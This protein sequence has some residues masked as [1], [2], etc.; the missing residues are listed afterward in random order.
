MAVSPVEIRHVR[1]KKTF[2]GGFRRPAVEELLAEIADSFEE[3]W[4]ERADLRD[5]VDHL[6]AEL[7]R[8]REVE[9]LLRETL[10][11]AERSAIELKDQARTEA[12]LVVREAHTSARSITQEALVERERLLGE[13]ARVRALLQAALTSVGESV[14]VAVEAAAEAA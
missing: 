4:R 5:R 9:G 6:E 10:L 3:V 2:I 11:S 7:R 14:P 8:H 13:A 1:L 12:E